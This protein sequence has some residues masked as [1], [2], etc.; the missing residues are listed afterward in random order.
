MYSSS[1][2]TRLL[3]AVCGREKSGVMRRKKN[4]YCNVSRYDMISINSWI[5]SEG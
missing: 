2:L 1:S 4:F 5:N 3:A